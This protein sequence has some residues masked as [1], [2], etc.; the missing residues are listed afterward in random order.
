MPYGC[1]W[2][3]EQ[4]FF[5]QAVSFVLL[6]H[7]LGVTEYGIFSGA[8]ALISLATPY[9]TLGAGMLFMRY[10]SADRSQAGLY[11]GN[12]L[13]LTTTVSLLIALVFYFAGPAIAHI[14]SHLIFVLL[15]IANC[16]FGQIA[17]V[18]GTVF[19]TFEKMRYTSILGF[20]STLGRLL[21][22][23]IML[24]VLHRATA[25]Q[26]S[27]GFLIASG[28]RRACLVDLGRKR[29]RSH[30]VEPGAHKAKGPRGGGLFLCRDD[31]ECL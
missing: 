21:V 3:R 7:L 14:Q 5:L 12:T 11:W 15:A 23:L 6:A 18:A 16:L 30:D 9:S 2:G 27:L 29:N 24:A 22:L 1:S 25:V 28:A 4:T 17:A 31:R 19:Q 20:L 10:V 26:W 8:Y 13:L